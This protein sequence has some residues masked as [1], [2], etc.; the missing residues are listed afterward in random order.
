MVPIDTSISM[1]DEPSSGS[2]ARASPASGF[3]RTGASRS[4]EAYQAT[5]ACRI[6]SWNARSACTSRAFW[7]S[8][9]ALM[10]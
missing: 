2:M 7:T 6:A 9:S 8:P 10:P 5:G 1:F 4:S 3:R